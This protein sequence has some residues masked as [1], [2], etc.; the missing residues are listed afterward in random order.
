MDTKV[1]NTNCYHFIM[2]L[3]LSS[4][5]LYYNDINDDNDSKSIKIITTIYIIIDN[6]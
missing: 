4:I 3:S 2:W 6:T 5:I 1:V